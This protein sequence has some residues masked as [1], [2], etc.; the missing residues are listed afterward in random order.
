MGPLWPAAPPLTRGSTRSTT[1]MARPRLGSPAHAGI[2]P[3]G[4]TGLIKENRL[5]RSRGDRPSSAQ[6]V[7]LRWRAP[8][9][10]RG[11]TPRQFPPVSERL[12]S[13][14]HAGI[15]PPPTYRTSNPTWLPR[16]RGD[17]PVSRNRERLN[18]WAPP[19]T[20]GST[21]DQ[22]S[23]ARNPAGSPAHAGI[24]PVVLVNVETLDWLPRSRGD[25]P[26]YDHPH[27]PPLTAPPLTRGSTRR[28]RIGLLCQP[29]S[30]AHAGIDPSRFSCMYL[31]KRLPRSRGDRPLIAEMGRHGLVAPPLTRGST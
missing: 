11:S 10:T 31:F 24:D 22:P 30:P 21:P 9:L 12:G 27:P 4:W 7:R 6:V 18:E 16:S 25:R 28:Q 14:A 19:L 23:P 3:A 13:P 26:L 15:D 29:G 1:W 2:D 8:P 17:R 5:P 20:R